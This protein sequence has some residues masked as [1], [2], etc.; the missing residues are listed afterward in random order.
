MFFS[1]K[2]VF[3][4]TLK[5]FM[6]LYEQYKLYYDMDKKNVTYE[7]LDKKQAKDDEWL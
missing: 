4:M 1:E 2:E 5:K 7:E 3:R 6:C